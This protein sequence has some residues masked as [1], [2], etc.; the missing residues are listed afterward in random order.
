MPLRRTL[1]VLSCAL[2]GANAALAQPPAASFDFL[3]GDRRDTGDQMR[4]CVGL[5]RADL[6]GPLIAAAAIDTNI[7]ETRFSGSSAA[8][9]T[10][11]GRWACVKHSEAGYPAWPLE[12]LDNIVSIEGVDAQAV[13]TWRLGLLEQ[14]RHHGQALGLIKFPQGN[15]YEVAI[16]ADKNKLLLARWRLRDLQP[17]SFDE[18]A[19]AAVLDGRG[20]TRIRSVRL[21]HGDGDWHSVVPPKAVHWPVAGN[22]AMPPATSTTTVDRL[23]DSEWERKGERLRFDVDGGVTSTATPPRGGHWQVVEPGLLRIRWTDKSFETLRVVAAGVQLSGIN[24]RTRAAEASH[25]E[26][27]L[28]VPVVYEMVYKPEGLSTATSS[29]QPPSANPRTAVLLAF[30]RDLKALSTGPEGTPPDPL[31]SR[32]RALLSPAGTQALQDVLRQPVPTEAG[33][34]L[35]ASLRVIDA[36]GPL[37]QA[38]ATGLRRDPERF[39]EAQLD[40]SNLST[41]LR[42]SK[43][44]LAQEMADLFDDNGSRSL[45]P[46]TRDRAQ[47]LL[48]NHEA[49]LA[50]L[51]PLL[52][53]QAR[54]RLQQLKQDFAGL[55]AITAP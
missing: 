50:K 29:P 49:D 33:T 34:L 23:I 46:T 43:I 2:L 52:Q 4:A 55:T 9:V 36:L 13:K 54:A 31:D 18:A 39:G 12:A 53:P 38:T 19:Y 44:M 35:L 24:R 26:E 7:T 25:P 20:L 21:G 11:R 6:K 45:D 41:R 47:R 5:T 17:G 3:S 8:I 27:E 37:T 15:A 32:A 48:K 28:Q 42:L 30:E 40:L 1:G 22:W 14:L 51:P 16:D 10:Q